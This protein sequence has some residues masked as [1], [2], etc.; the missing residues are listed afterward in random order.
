MM[1]CE[2]QYWNQAETQHH[3]QVVDNAKQALERHK[4]PK[5]QWREAI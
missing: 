1:K 3:H 2:D 4:K 5:I